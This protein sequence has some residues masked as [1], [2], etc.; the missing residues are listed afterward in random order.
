MTPVDLPKKLLG[1]SGVARFEVSDV[2]TFTR[3]L[4]D[5]GVIDRG[6]PHTAC[7]PIPTYL[8]YKIVSSRIMPDGWIAVRSQEGRLIQLI[9]Y[10]PEH[11]S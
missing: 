3:D 1:F 5:F 7:D 9:R 11:C 10:L 8:G 4:Q 2:L 6:P